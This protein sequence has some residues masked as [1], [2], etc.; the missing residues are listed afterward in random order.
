MWIYVSHPPVKMFL[1]TN[2]TRK[3]DDHKHVNKGTQS[4]NVDVIGFA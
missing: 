4:I 2:G 1:N 3:Y